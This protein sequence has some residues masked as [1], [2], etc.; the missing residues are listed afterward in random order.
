MLF[1]ALYV[2]FILLMSI[3]LSSLCQDWRPFL[4]RCGQIVY[5]FEE[6]LLHT[7]GNFEEQY[8]VGV[9]HYHQFLHFC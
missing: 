6:I 8:K 4:R 3:P 7:H 9:L 2:A 5:E 1:V